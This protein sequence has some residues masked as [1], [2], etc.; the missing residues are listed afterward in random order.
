MSSNLVGNTAIQ[1]TL[2]VTMSN[3]IR[4]TNKLKFSFT[5]NMMYLYFLFIVSTNKK[6]PMKGLS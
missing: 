6:T 1:T 3:K 2:V 4:I 5:L